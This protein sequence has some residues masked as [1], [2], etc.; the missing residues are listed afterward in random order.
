MVSCRLRWR[1]STANEARCE[2]SEISTRCFRT[3]TTTIALGCTKPQ[4]P[5]PRRRCVGSGALLALTMMQR[6]VVPSLAPLAQV[7][8][9]QR[10]TLSTSKCISWQSLTRI[11]GARYAHCHGSSASGTRGRQVPIVF[12]TE[13]LSCSDKLLKRTA[14]TSVY[15][16]AARRTWRVRCRE[17]RHYHEAQNPLCILPVQQIGS[18]CTRI[19]PTGSHAIN[20][21]AQLICCHRVS[22][23][24]KEL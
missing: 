2:C 9:S 17:R 24:R 22:R 19:R 11:L 6:R 8:I 10:R 1:C 3:T 13:H 5:P 4:C 7:R 14:D 12:S 23:S 21:Q 15:F 16:L 20:R 18:L